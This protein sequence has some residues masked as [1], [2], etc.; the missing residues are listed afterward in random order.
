MKLAVF[1]IR[2]LKRLAYLL[3]VSKDRLLQVSDN[4]HQLYRAGH[5]FVPYKDAR[6]IHIPVQSLAIM[7]KCILERV[8]ADFRPHDCS[9]GGVRHRTSAANAE[10]HLD[11]SFL[12]K[13]DVR[14]FYTNVHH[15]WVQ[16]LFER[17]LGCIPPVAS[18][19]RRLLTH[20]GGLPQG[21]CTSPAL[22]DQILRP[23]D[24]RL[25]NALTCRGV[26]YTRWVDDMTFSAMFSLRTYVPF[27]QK[28]LKPYGLTIHSE[29]SKAARQFGPGEMAV[30]TGLCCRGRVSVAQT[31][32]DTIRKEM[33]IAWRFAEGHSTELPP[34]GRET[35][36]GTIRY[37]GRFSR[38]QAK[39][40]MNLFDSVKWS[41]LEP[42]R[43]PGK[44][45]RVVI[46]STPS[47]AAASISDGAPWQ[48]R[49]N[50]FGR[51]GPGRPR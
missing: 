28:M 13:M 23:L 47:D 14:K 36:W 4:A 51:A 26:T 35:Y 17:R 34:Y 15:R 33:R 18:T 25:Q 1:P 6:P 44:R 32:I 7:Q 8:F 43:L 45:G 29:G 40:L 9:Y 22:A 48:G 21:T 27:V 11:N 46:A 3:G 31:Y 2:S 12:M 49:T 20:N 38:R 10:M 16:Q 19:L 39:E 5:L 30:V 50:T 42:L 41:A 24:T 37:I